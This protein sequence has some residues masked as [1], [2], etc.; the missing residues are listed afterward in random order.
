MRHESRILAPGMENKRCVQPWSQAEREPP[1][2]CRLDFARCGDSQ[3]RGDRRTSPPG[4]DPNIPQ[5]AEG[6]LEADTG[7][8][9]WGHTCSISGSPHQLHPLRRQRVVHLA[10]HLRAGSE[11]KENH[12]S[13]C[14]ST[15][16]GLTHCSGRNWGTWQFSPTEYGLT[17]PMTS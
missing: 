9:G 14:G 7:K 5:P 10:A 12:H 1:R 15:G 2:L 13:R 6:P 11:R 16:Q 4:P 8:R 3:L 17:V